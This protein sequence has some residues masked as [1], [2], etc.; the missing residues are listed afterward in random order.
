VKDTAS[1]MRVVKKSSLKKIYPLPDGLHFTP[2]MSARALLNE[3]II[4]SEENMPYHEREGESKLSVTKD[5]VRFLK[6]ILSTAFLYRP[7]VIFN[8][9]A[10]F[11]SLLAGIVML[12]PLNYYFQFHRVEEVMIY[13]FIV[14]EVLGVFAFLLFASSYIVQSTIR[15]SI[16]DSSDFNSRKG[17]ASAF[18]ESKI[19]TVVAFVLLVVGFVS[20]FNS[21]IIR[22]ETGKTYEHWSRYFLFSFSEIIA[23]I[24]FITK[25]SRITLKLVK[26]R[27]LFIQSDLYKEL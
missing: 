18:F 14:G 17:T 10:V 6:V 8:S 11:V 19:S 12:Q 24:I 21:L 3:H 27:L 1:G 4:I 16:L 9:L 20:I 13:R 26:N 7:Q 23:L 2:A 25:F 22:L 5:G 15:L